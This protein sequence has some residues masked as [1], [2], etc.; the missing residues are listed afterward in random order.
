MGKRAK[1][2]YVLVG[3]LLMAVIMISIVPAFSATGSQT[4]KATYNNI[5]IV[6]DGETITPRD[7]SGKIVEPFLVGGTNYLPVR[8]MCEAIGYNVEWDGATQTVYVWSGGN[9]NEKP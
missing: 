8:A 1:I 6:I 4:L 5:K 9:G 2:G 7:A 3:M